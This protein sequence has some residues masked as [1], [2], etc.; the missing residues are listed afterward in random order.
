MSCHRVQSHLLILNKAFGTLERSNEGGMT[1][2]LIFN[3]HLSE[4]SFSLLSVLRSLL[5]IGGAHIW[6]ES[7]I[8]SLNCPDSFI[9]ACH[10][11]FEKCVSKQISTLLDE[12]L[13]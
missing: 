10:R 5:Y 13:E 3:R 6:D 8:C 11:K 1:I 12:F 9:I 7:L 2:E 4:E